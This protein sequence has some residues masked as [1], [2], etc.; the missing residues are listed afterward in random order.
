MPSSKDITK[1]ILQENLKWRDILTAGLQFAY[2]YFISSF[3]YVGRKHTFLL[4]PSQALPA[5]YYQS[6]DFSQNY[7]TTLS[8]VAFNHSFHHELRDVVRSYLQSEHT[9]AWIK[10]RGRHICA[11]THVC[12]C[13]CAC[14]RR[15]TVANTKSPLVLGEPHSRSGR[16]KATQ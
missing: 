8:F 1:V 7:R 16:T 12:M 13:V 3:F 6:Q 11:R 4:C 10:C 5:C 2:P 15:T 14:M 9:A